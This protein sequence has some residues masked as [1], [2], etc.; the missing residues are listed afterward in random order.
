MTELSSVVDLARNGVDRRTIIKGAAWTLPVIALAVAA[1]AA[2][3]STV[4]AGPYVLNGSCG[5]TG[6]L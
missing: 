2:A 6:V 1:P 4:D 3:A 5:T